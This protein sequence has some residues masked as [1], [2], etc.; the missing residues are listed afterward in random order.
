M[1]RPDYPTTLEMRS[2]RRDAMWLLAEQ[3]N[4]YQHPVKVT[5]ECQQEQGHFVTVSRGY[6]ASRKEALMYLMDC[7]DTLSGD[8]DHVW[9]DDDEGYT[10]ALLQASLTTGL[11]T[12]L[13]IHNPA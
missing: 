8:Y 4:P 9:L 13:S 5:V 11:W 2:E 10:M 12:I 3:A 6:F 7:A 1:E